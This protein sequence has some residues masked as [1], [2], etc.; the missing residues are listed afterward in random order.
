MSVFVATILPEG[1]GS[2]TIA[3]GNSPGEAVRNAWRVY[4]KKQQKSELDLDDYLTDVTIKNGCIYDGEMP[5]GD[6]GPA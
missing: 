5:C 1:P 3:T 2:K 6:V 4:F